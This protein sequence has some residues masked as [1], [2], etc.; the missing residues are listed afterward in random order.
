MAA[1]SALMEA[2]RLRV[3]HGDSCETSTG[4]RCEMTAQDGIDVGGR[5]CLLLSALFGF[6]LLG[7]LGLQLILNLL[8]PLRTESSQ[9]IIVVGCHRG[10]SSH[11]PPSILGQTG[12]LC[13]G[14]LTDRMGHVVNQ[15]FVRQP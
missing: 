2:A 15:L 11:F 3:S 10:H 6:E 12:V 1:K 7:G 5:R 9:L 4:V 8:H 13:F 14:F